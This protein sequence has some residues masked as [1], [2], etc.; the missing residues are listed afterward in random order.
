MNGDNVTTDTHPASNPQPPGTPTAQPDAGPPAFPL[1]PP[2]TDR[3]AIPNSRRPAAA[4]TPTAPA[5]ADKITLTA[6]PVPVQPVTA[7][8]TQAPDAPDHVPTASAPS[9]A[10]PDRDTPTHV[11]VPINE[12]QESAD[13]RLPDPPR[14]PATDR[15]EPPSPAR[16]DAPT[17]AGPSTTAG[18]DISSFAPAASG[19]RADA[20]PPA[21]VG[22]GAGDAAAREP[23]LR[24]TVTELRL[25]AFKSHRGA[26]FPL[27]P[28]TVFAGGGGAGKSSV[29]EALVL[30][31]RLAAGDELGTVVQEV[32]RGGA[33]ACA[34]D[35]SRPDE[36]GRRGFHLGCT[37]DG[38]EGDV[39][40]DL[41]VQTEPELRIV[42][43]RL[44]GYGITLLSTALRD[45]ERPSVQAAWHTAGAVPVTRAPLP[46]SRLAT[47][48]L[49]LRVAGITRGQR[50][51]LA[52]AE[53]MIIGLRAVFPVSPVPSRMRAPVPVGD[54]MLRST[55]DNL[56][57]VLNRTGD[58][59]RIRHGIL[60]DTVRSVVDGTLE[61][62]V[63]V[64]RE[65]P[66]P[67]D[68]DARDAVRGSRGRASGRGAGMP[69]GRGGRAPARAGGTSRPGCPGGSGRAAPMSVP[70]PGVV[71]A[72]DRGGLGLTTIDRLGDSQ[73]R[74]L[75]MALVLLTGPGVLEMDQGIEVPAAL[76]AMTVVAEGLDSGLD[77]VQTNALLSVALRAAE[78]GHVRVVATALDP[79]AVSVDGITV[80]LLE[81]GPSSRSVAGH[82]VTVVPPPTA[83]PGA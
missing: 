37:V 66:V 50:Q 69:A 20:V 6:A 80:V 35:G 26:V 12:P 27:G 1:P 25:S 4:P 42:G 34:P 76:R 31:A 81:R 58:E 53:Q 51:V 79:A 82:P 15:S 68:P 78:H 7:P 40:L 16:A 24:P 72:L 70:R 44:T 43:E 75:A 49:P 41:A 62:V 39:R 59:C 67:E 30:L 9:G 77:T 8:H 14:P 48:V 36:Q 3:C 21:A 45:P 32:V 63:T 17:H 13:P 46:D 28:V 33:A 19:Q 55:C 74:F 57:A 10:G 5:A 61:G 52:A 11:S 71:A 60:V 73:L 65:I 29:L 38:P 22:P 23:V 2:P 56:S 54:G 18:A 64:E 83:V 47:A